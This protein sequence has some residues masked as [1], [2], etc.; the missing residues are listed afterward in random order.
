MSRPARACRIAALL[1][2][3]NQPLASAAGNAVEVAYAVDYLTGTRAR[4]ALPRGHR[5]ARRRRC[6]CSA[7]SPRSTREGEARIEEAIA[8]GRAAEAFG[9]M[10][11]AL[12]GPADFAR[13]LRAS[14]SRRRPSCG[15]FDPKGAGIVQAIATRELGVAVVAIGG[16]RTSPEQR[17]D[18]AIGLSELAAHRRAASATAARSP[19]CTPARRSSSAMPP[20][21]RAAG[22]PARRRAGGARARHRRAHRSRPMSFLVAITAWDPQPWLERFRKLMPERRVVRPRR[23]LRSGRGRAMPPPGSTRPAASPALPNLKA[24]FS[25]GAGV[26]H[27]LGDP[28]AARACRSCASSTRT[29]PTA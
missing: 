10:V 3:M 25:L 24:L 20:R 22:V 15:R 4:G 16:G 27:L 11:A 26:D 14:S 9:R 18:H 17:I 23:A 1:T 8:S 21:R 7:D 2:D 6:W 5:R 13:A 29:S 28:A 19:S 12:G